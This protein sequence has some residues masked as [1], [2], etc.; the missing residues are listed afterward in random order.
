[1][2]NAISGWVAFLPHRPVG[3]RT[4]AHRRP[5]PPWRWRILPLSRLF[6]MPSPRRVPPPWT[7]EEPDACF[8]VRDA[9][10]QGGT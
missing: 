10:G 2:I 6:S 3:G 7:A 5:A 4:T 1:M 8:I 9:N